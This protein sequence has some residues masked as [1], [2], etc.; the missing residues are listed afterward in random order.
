MFFYDSFLLSSINYCLREGGD[1]EMDL[2]IA[3]AGRKDVSATLRAEALATLG[4]WANPSPL[5]RVDGRYRGVV[6]RESGPVVT[7]VKANMGSFLREKDPEVLVSIAQML[8][9]LGISDYNSDLGSIFSSNKN[10]DVRSAMLKTLGKLNYG[11]METLVRQGMGDKDREV[12][13]TAVGLISKLD[14]SKEKLP[15]VVDPIFKSGTT[16]E[17]QE[18]LH[19]LGEM[20][21]EKSVPVLEGLIDRLA[22][23]KLSPD[24]T[25]DLMEAVNATKSEALIAKLAPLEKKGT[26][27]DAYKETLYGGNGRKG[28]DYFMNSSAGQ[29]ARCHSVNGQGGTVGPPLQHSGSSLAR[30]QILRAMIA[31]SARLAPGYG[32]VSLELKDGQKT[33]GILLEEHKDKL[34]LQTSQAEPLEVPISRIVK[35]TN[36]PSSMPP[37]GSVMS[38]REIR[39][40]V[41]FLANMK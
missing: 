22:K 37:M 16:R 33:N 25:L 38:K 12:R 36:I 9:N 6:K 3:F 41:E 10:P 8:G 39:D 23:G 30:E 18:V 19:V 31:P 11:D 7:K 40:M 17:Q 28:W 13:T 1:K 24:V 15:S 4:T 35:R 14:I 34:I 29:C 26:T 27:V 20:P 32:S 5:D 2:L 21:L